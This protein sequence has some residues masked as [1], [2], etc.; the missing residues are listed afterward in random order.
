MLSGSC[1]SGREL[2]S[3]GRGLARYSLVALEEHMLS[4]VS[5]ELTAIAFFLL[6]A[7]A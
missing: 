4:P 6:R 3:M 5:H 2:V 7:G 1:R